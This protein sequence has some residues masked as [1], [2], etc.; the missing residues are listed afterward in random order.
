MPSAGIL[1]LPE[2]F[3]AGRFAAVLDRGLARADVTP[4][5]QR[6]RQ[7]NQNMTAVGRFT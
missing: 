2:R 5:G 4:C 6:K 1:R 7:P 3:L